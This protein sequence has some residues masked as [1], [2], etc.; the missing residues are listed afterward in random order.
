M[1]IL[2]IP[3][4]SGK[5]VSMPSK[6]SSPHQF[7][8]RKKSRR[9]VDVGEGGSGSRPTR[10]HSKR[11]VHRAYPRGHM[12]IDTEIEEENP[13]DTSDDESIED[14]TYSMSPVPPSENNV[15]DEIES[16]DSRVRHEVEEEK[17]GMVQGTLNPRSRRR[18]PFHPSLTIRSPHKPLRYH[19]T[20]YKGKWATKQVKKLQK[21]DPRSQQRDASD[22]RFH[23]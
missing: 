8:R 10:R 18:A 19:V 17:E 3:F 6:G 15:E 16:N 13:M 11:I 14:E 12:R 22:Y 1:H 9:D 5:T 2:Y 7:E 20:S 21:V 23:T 4:F